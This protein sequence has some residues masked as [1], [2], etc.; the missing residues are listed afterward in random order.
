MDSSSDRLYSFAW[1]RLINDGI[2]ANFFEVATCHK[3]RKNLFHEAFD[4]WVAPKANKLEY[5]NNIKYSWLELLSLEDKFSWLKKEKTQCSW[6]WSYIKKPKV[7]IAYQSYPLVNVTETRNAIITSI[8]LFNASLEEKI[9]LIQR[10]KKAWEE[11]V[12]RAKNKAKTLKSNKKNPV[13][14]QTT[15]LKS[16]GVVIT[17]LSSSKPLELTMEDI[18]N[19]LR[20]T[21]QSSS[22]IAILEKKIEEQC[23]LLQHSTINLK[24]HNAF[25]QKLSENEKI[26]AREKANTKMKEVFCRRPDSLELHEL[27]TFSTITLKK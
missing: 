23:L 6:A 22:Y 5:L 24:K 19:L 12:K 18:I 8:D 15:E 10:M 25:N 17:P 7:N 14:K 9:K 11:K 21:S 3:E 20:Q 16:K 4:L 1:F 26:R 2:V 13:K 27:K